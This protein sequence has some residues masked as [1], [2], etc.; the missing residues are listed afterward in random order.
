[1]N[2]TEFKKISEKEFQYLELYGNVYGYQMQPG[3]KWNKGLPQKEISNLESKFGFK[4]PIEYRKF[5]S[6]MNGLDTD[7]IFIDPEEKE[8]VS[9]SQLYYEY[10]KDFNSQIVLLSELEKYKLYLHEALESSGYDVNGIEGYIPT[11]AHRALVVFK[12]KSLSPVVSV[13]GNNIILLADNIADYW[14]LELNIA[15]CFPQNH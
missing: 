7:L 10:P 14:V 6:V 1:M 13:W 15:H 8:S 5:I 4:F 9:Y 12:D 2:W 11:Y 3:T